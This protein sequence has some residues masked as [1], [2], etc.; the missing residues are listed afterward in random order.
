MKSPMLNLDTFANKIVY[1]LFGSRNERKI[2]LLQSLVQAINQHEDDSQRASDDELRARIKAARLSLSQKRKLDDLLPEIFAITREAARRT[3]GQRPFDVQLTGGIILHEGNIAEMK[4]GE[5]KTLAATLPAV[6]N[7]LTGGGVHIVTVNDYLAQRDSAWMGQIYNFLGLSVGCITHDMDDDARKQAYA[8]DITYGT[9][10]EFGFD[11][12]RDN[13]KFHLEDM[14][15]RGHAFAIVDEVDS[16]LIDEARTPLI[17]SGPVEDKSDLYT[18]INALIPELDPSSY[19]MDE[20]T[21]SVNL[22]DDGNEVME[23]I[24]R[25]ENLLGPS[26]LYEAE[27]ISLVHHVNQA[28]RAHKLFQR[29]RDYIVRDGKVIIIDEFTGRMM[30][31]RRYSDGL[32]QALEAKENVPIEA[33][34]QTLASITFQNYFRMYRKL[35]GMTGTAMTERDEFLDIYGLDVLAVPTNLPVCRVDE[36]DEVYLTQQE[37]YDAIVDKIADCHQRGQPVL[38]GTTSISK[39]EHLSALLKK[40]RTPHNVLNARYH[41]QEAQIIAAAG[42]PHAVTIATNMAGRGTDIQLGGN[43]DMNLAELPDEETRNESREALEADILAKRAKV[44]EQGGLFV[45]GTERHES[46]RIDNQLRGRS[47]RQGDPGGSHFFLS[48][49]D[50]L[51]R[52]FGSDRMGGILQK[53]G[54]K[55]GEAIIHP[56]VNKALEKAQKKV[57]GRNFDI[58]KNLLKFDNVMNDQRKVVFEQRLDFLRSDNVAE[59]INDMREEIIDRLITAYIPE[60][61]WPEEWDVK[62]FDEEAQQSLGLELPIADWAK[63]EGIS[64]EI[65]RARVVEICDQCLAE[66]FAVAPPEIATQIQKA[67]LIRALDHHWREH[68]QRLEHLRQVVGLRGFGQRD[69]LNEYKGEAFELFENFLLDL[70]K[71]VTRQTITLQLVEDGAAKEPLTEELPEMELHHASAP[72]PPEA[73]MPILAGEGAA[74]TPP[75]AAPPVARMPELNDQKTPRNAPCPC[76]SGKKFKHCHGRNV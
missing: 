41:E 47:G 34:N 30:A 3:L 10:N 8:A 18:K 44:L 43:L 72:P 23:T 75:A 46:R 32:H 40:R 61:A 64:D 57:E 42:T 6:L 66:K 15:Q 56:W 19:D 17:I 5:G 73:A 69:P 24:L 35:A 55:Q 22:S 20:K 71:D 14:A 25:R 29:D 51:M 12:L 11:Y 65:V 52:I 2:R 76:G 68:L 48:L 45:L 53:L 63:E 13:M 16:I 59:I 37:K 21:R 1:S 9:N 54:L 74:P 50:D 7:A 67:V 70:R 36:D 58:R 28:L 33:E 39:S 60:K 38:V 31:G 4:T 49:D 27:N 62:G 26:A